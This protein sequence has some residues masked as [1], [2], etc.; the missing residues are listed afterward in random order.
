MRILI[1][2]GGSVGG[3]LAQDL[4]EPF[5]LIESDPSRV[6][7]LRDL[8]RGKEVKYSIVHGDG[9][10]VETIEKA[11]KDFDVA[12]V[13]MNKDFE[14]LE[15]VSI[16]KGLGIPRIIARVNKSHN[17]YR[18]IGMGAE[19]FQH[20]I[21]YEEGLIKTMIFPD[22]SHAV[23][24]FV[25]E[26]S[27]AA[28]RTIKE[29]SLPEGA[30]IGSILRD[31][32]LIPPTPSTQIMVGDLIA[33]DTVGK[34]AK[35]VWRIFSKSGKVESSGHILFPLTGDKDLQSVKEVEQ[36]AKRLGSEIVFISTP[37]NEGLVIAAR[38]FISK[39]IPFSVITSGSDEGRLLEDP[40]SI[41]LPGLGKKEKALQY[42]IRNHMEEGSPHLDVFVIS[43]P[44]LPFIY[45]P[46][47]SLTLD[48]MIMSSPMPVLIS[49]T[50]KKYRKILLYLHT[51]CVQ[52]ISI[53]IQ[54]CRAFGSSIT[55]VYKPRYSKRA[56]YLKRFAKVYNIKV[57]ERK[58]VGNPT[59]EFIK[60]V[61]ENYYDL[62]IIKK[63]L[64]DIQTS[65]MRR[66][67]H[68]WSGSVMLVP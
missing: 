21:G 12:V 38:G 18:F 15:A 14:N 45:M 22:A 55:A 48:R 63:D 50:T 52:E 9:N 67:V 32:E 36:M 4:E 16:L 57:E 66:L 10:S 3:K 39:R 40:S 19:V 27:P 20:P 64:K 62:V 35:D 59:V 17:M 34:K 25:R 2:G 42:L 37:G 65:Q 58:V 61:K 23:Q 44:G 24:I 26:G 30:V 11:G 7:E 51:N 5:A 46:F 53:A 33:I 47:L 41:Y 28:D 56:Q 6:W 29:L 60:E 31:E 49:R 8:L 54:I 68:L 43:N 13:L 1:L